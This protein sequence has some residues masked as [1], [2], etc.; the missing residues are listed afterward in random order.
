M[1]SKHFVTAVTLLGTALLLSAP[2]HANTVLSLTDVGTTANGDYAL[3][4]TATGTAT[5]I[6]FGGYNIPYFEYVSNIGL[7]HQGGAN[8]NS[9]FG[10]WNFTQAASGSLATFYSDGTSIPA[11]VFGGTTIGSYDIFSDRGDNGRRFL[12]AGFHFPQ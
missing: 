8:P 1:K 12:H 6:S 3:S 5:T 10:G 2:A 11:L 4:F 7:Y 9:L